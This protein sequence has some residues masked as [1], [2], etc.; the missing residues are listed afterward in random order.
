VAD[1]VRA[2]DPEL[3]ERLTAEGPDLT[4]SRAAIRFDTFL[5]ASAATVLITR[6]FLAATGYPQ[7]GGHSQLHVAH[8]LWGGLL[9]GLAMTVMMVSLGSAA[10]YW[11][12][13]IGGIGF[14]LFIDEIGKFLT[15]DVNYF[16]RP[17]PAIIYGV[18]ITAYV[19][20][21]EVINRV[22]LTGPRTRALAAIAIADNELGQ[23]TPARRETVETLLSAY[24]ASESDQFYRRLLVATSTRHRRSTEE[25]VARSTT[26]LH[27]IFLAAARRAWV[28]VVVLAFLIY[29]VV[30]ALATL[31]YLIIAVWITHDD[32]SKVSPSDIANFA[33]NVVQVT[34]IAIGLALLARHQ[35]RVGL[36]P[37]RAGLFFSLMF[38]TVMEFEDQQFH[39][40][41]DFAI[42]ALLY[43]IVGAA[44]EAE[45]RGEIG[46]RRSQPDHSPVAAASLPA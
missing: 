6:A 41:L 21:R 15:K 40:L 14:G 2:S 43:T 25:W 27:S 37:I 46:S 22:K 9:L 24:S 33:G 20:G 10:R 36:R 5:F 26:W 4:D 23:L 16:F 13:L 1:D 38:T 42:G 34:L 44:A 35:W 8:V 45:R 32:T 19:L 31:G 17:A 12:S 7:V 28:R 30:A 39:A 18:L 11:A 3:L 29:E